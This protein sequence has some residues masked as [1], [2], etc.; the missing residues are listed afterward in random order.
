MA[1]VLALSEDGPTGPNAGG[2][3]APPEEFE[4]QP[5]NTSINYHI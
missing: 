1:T 2:G 3:N 5:F 4:L